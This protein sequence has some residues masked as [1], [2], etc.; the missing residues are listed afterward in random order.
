MVEENFLFADVNECLLVAMGEEIV[1]GVGIIVVSEDNPYIFTVDT[2]SGILGVGVVL[3]RAVAEDKVAVDEDGILF[4]VFNFGVNPIENEFIHGLDG[5][6]AHRLP[7]IAGRLVFFVCCQ[8][9][10]CHELDAIT[11]LHYVPVEQMGIAQENCLTIDSMP[12]HSSVLTW[13]FNFVHIIP[14]GGWFV[15]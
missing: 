5:F 8:V 14:E 2:I 11:I 3:L 9:L 6:L 10:Y 13:L 1:D 15:N 12:V 4:R 7:T